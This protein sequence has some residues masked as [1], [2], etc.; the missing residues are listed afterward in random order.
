M[1]LASLDRG[2]DR[3]WGGRRNEG[4]CGWSGALAPCE[5]NLKVR[6]SWGSKRSNV[7]V[8]LMFTSGLHL[9]P[10]GWVVLS[11]PLLT[12]E[13]RFQETQIR[14]KSQS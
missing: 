1:E 12:K 4:R 13:M 6:V 14:P 7:T 8:G 2:V 3:T 10:V 9:C 11:L 5:G